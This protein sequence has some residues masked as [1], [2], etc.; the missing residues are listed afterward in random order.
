MLHIPT[1]ITL[2]VAIE[3]K[4]TACPRALNVS[5][6]FLFTLCESVTVAFIVV[7]Y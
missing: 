2:F 7:V 5:M 6:L 1:L 4:N 3:C